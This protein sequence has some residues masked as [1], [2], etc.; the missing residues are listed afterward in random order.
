[1]KTLSRPFITLV[2]C[3]FA[4]HLFAQAIFLKVDQLTT[5]GSPYEGFTDYVEI[6]SR[7]LGAIKEVS[8]TAG[9]GSGSGKAQFQELVITKPSDK[10]S[11]RL[12]D[13]LVNGKRIQEME[14]VTTIN[15][16]N[17]G[18][19]IVVNKMEF[20]DVQVSNISSAGVKDCETGCQGI[21][22]SFKLV[23]TRIKITTYSQN[24]NGAWQADPYVFMYNVAS[25]QN[26]F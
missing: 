16:A 20:K 8:T 2:F 9:S 24:E 6:N 12:W 5:D 21:I 7:Q 17:G 1:M 14:I 11:N 4:Q 10:L 3:L 13:F 23:Y 26:Q 25:G 18:S 22:E 15:A 19:R